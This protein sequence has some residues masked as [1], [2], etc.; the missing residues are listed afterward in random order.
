[1]KPASKTNRNEVQ[2]FEHENLGG[3]KEPHKA[4]Q[5]KYKA[6]QTKAKSHKQALPCAWRTAKGE[7][8]S[9]KNASATSS[10]NFNS[11]RRGGRQSP[12]VT[13]G[14]RGGQGAGQS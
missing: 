13:P 1:M 5:T 14:V 2:E 8:T 10:E 12:S 4:K 6:N 9:T 3:E 7:W 11:E